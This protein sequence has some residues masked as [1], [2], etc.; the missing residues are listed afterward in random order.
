MRKSDDLQ[1]VYYQK[2]MAFLRQMGG[3]FSA[4]YPKIAR[5]LS[6]TENQ[7]ADPHVERLLESF[8]FLTGYLQQDIENQFPRISSA[9]LG[10]LY[11]YLVQPIPSMS[12]AHFKPDTQKP[13]TTSYQVPKNFSVFAEAREGE[14]CRFR[15]CYPVEMWPIEVKSVK[16]VKSDQYA[17]T[18]NF[19]S[20]T[21][22]IKIS[23][24]ALKTPLKELNLKKLRFYINAHRT[25]SHILY[26]ALFEKK[27]RVLIKEGESGRIVQTQEDAIKQVGFSL[28]ENVV[29]AAKNGHP[30]Y[31]LVQEYF[32]F[33]KK[34]MFFDLEGLDF[35]HCQEGAE[36]FIPI[37]YQD[38]LQSV[39]ISEKVLLLGCTPIINLFPRTSEPIRF[40]RKKIEYRLVPDYRREMTTEIYSLDKVFASN[41]DSV[42]IDEMRPYFSYDHH[43]FKNK[44]TA[45]WFGRRVSSSNP[46]IPGTDFFLSF[47]DWDFH[48]RAPKTEVVYAR[49]LCTNRAL[50][51]T[52][53]GN[54]VLQEDEGIP[55]QSIVCL[56]VPTNPIYPATE[57]STQW[58]LIS[59]LALSHL[60]LSSEPESLVALKEMLF[61]YSGSASEVAQSEINS[62]QSMH[63]ETVV[64]RLGAEAWKGFVKGTGVTLSLDFGESGSLGTFLFSAVLSRFMGL[65]T[66]I[67]SFTELSIKHKN[68]DEILKTWPIAAGNQSLF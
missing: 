59:S 45:F 48:P 43:S 19:C 18:K 38:E 28:D 23:L 50:A 55:A 15:T 56:H 22:L 5:R 16:L 42:E 34:F 31:R 30:A 66:Q 6:F 49:T 21:H 10:I 3:I 60:S 29:P 62:I 2:E 63:C 40:D 37:S 53:P 58:Q 8:A 4:K 1:L 32:S 35:S 52:V 39:A 47:V 14:I 41:I 11:P 51:T 61:L 33:P 17:F 9:L 27:Q 26:R 13:M 20:A 46:N 68:Q 54:T 12:I 44:D 36:I 64:R 7:S 67:N 24:H 57:G 25:E 65:Y